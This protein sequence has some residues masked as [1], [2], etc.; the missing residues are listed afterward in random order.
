M[1]MKNISVFIQEQPFYIKQ[2]P[3]KWKLKQQVVSLVVQ[4]L[5]I[6]HVLSEKEL[7]NQLQNMY[8]DPVE[9]RRYLVDFG[10][11]KR[12]KDGAK[13]WIPQPVISPITIRIY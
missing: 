3:K 10:F 11:V 4:H 5:S 13:Y 7:T 8:H 1:F 6:D 9:L 12:T 2:M